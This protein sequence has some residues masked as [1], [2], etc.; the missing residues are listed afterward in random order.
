MMCFSR[1]LVF[2]VV[3]LLL[4]ISGCAANRPRWFGAKEEPPPPGVVPPYERRAELRALAEQAVQRSPDEQER[5]AA[6]L[7]AQ[8]QRE[9]DPNQREE[10][11]RAVGRLPVPAAQSVLRT[12]SSDPNLNVR[13]AVCQAWSKQPPEVAVQELSLML[14]ER[15]DPDVRMDAAR[16]LGK[17]KD[18]RAVAA[19]AQTMSDPNPALQARVS[20][21]LADITGQD[22]GADAAAWQQYAAAGKAEAKPISLAER[23]RRYFD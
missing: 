23:M 9:P 18:R 6:D 3:G 21:S 4:T 15:N 16:Q 19:L 22:F 17:L 14:A 1:R 2:L 11:V 10:I 13:V 7:A 12:A 20:A 8:F 5:I